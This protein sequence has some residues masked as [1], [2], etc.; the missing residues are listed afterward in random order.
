MQSARPD[1][2]GL[3]LPKGLAAAKLEP[4]SGSGYFQFP[5]IRNPCAAVIQGPGQTTPPTIR[6]AAIF[7]T[8]SPS[9]L[10]RS[11]AAHYRPVCKA[12]MPI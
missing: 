8:P 10:R 1:H 4:D 5:A 6:A 3:R 2:R 7:Q 12:L 11:T 9:E